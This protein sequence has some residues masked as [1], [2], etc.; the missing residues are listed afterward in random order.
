MHVP[1]FVTSA[2]ISL[3]AAISFL[4]V[5]VSSNTIHIHFK[6]IGW[7]SILGISIISSVISMGTFFAG[8]KRIGPTKGAVLSMVEPVVTIT[9]STI[10]FHENMSLLQMIGGTIVLGGALLV[11][12]TS[13]KRKIVE[14]KMDF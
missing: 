12:L 3:F 6:F 1:P 8:V 14:N 2:Y 10:L 13:E 9:F 11:V 4:L 7:I 5:G